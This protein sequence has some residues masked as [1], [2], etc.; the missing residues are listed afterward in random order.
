MPVRGRRYSRHTLAKFIASPIKCAFIVL[1]TRAAISASRKALSLSFSIRCGPGDPINYPYETLRTGESAIYPVDRQRGGKDENT[2]RNIRHVH[3]DKE[4]R[5]LLLVRL[6][7][8]KSVGGLSYRLIPSFLS[9]RPLL[10]FR[11]LAERYLDLSFETL[12][13]K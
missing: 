6:S 4:H 8:A 13:K 11:T 3:F 1:V 10:W 12:N 7:L 5:H 9:R 2:C